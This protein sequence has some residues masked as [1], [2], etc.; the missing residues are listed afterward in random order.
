MI[1]ITVAISSEESGFET[2][3][4]RVHVR[5]S[6]PWIN[7]GM[8]K[9]CQACFSG[10]IEFPPEKEE[11]EK[12]PITL[13]SEITLWATRVSKGELESRRI[14]YHESKEKA[15]KFVEAFNAQPETPYKAFFDHERSF[16]IFSLLSMKLSKGLGGLPQYL[17]R[18]DTLWDL[19]NDGL[20]PWTP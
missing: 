14:Q 16:P 5:R 13:D 3:T 8:P 19:E 17:Y 7:I 2:Q 4:E 12:A 1:A 9:S 18:D 10:K 20:G 6:L 11:A 15:H